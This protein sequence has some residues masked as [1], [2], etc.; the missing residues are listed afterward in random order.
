MTTSTWKAA[1]PHPSCHCL[2]HTPLAP[3]RLWL[4]PA[5]FSL[6]EGVVNVLG[7]L[8]EPWLYR[9]HGFWSFV[10]QQRFS[11][12]FSFVPQSAFSHFCGLFVFCVALTLSR[13]S[14]YFRSKFEHDFFV[15]FG[16]FIF[17]KYPP[18]FSIKLQWISE[19]SSQLIAPEWY[20]EY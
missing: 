17:Y 14:R 10:S 15:S 20:F 12:F 1:S 18:V 4:C 19:Q 13:S 5:L 8:F 3:L 11:L 6:A 2:C 16:L 9:R 7:H